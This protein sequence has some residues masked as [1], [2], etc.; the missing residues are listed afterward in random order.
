MQLVAGTAEIPTSAFWR[1]WN[2]VS[3]YHTGGLAAGIL[4]SIW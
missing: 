4:K 3:L 2:T 1:H